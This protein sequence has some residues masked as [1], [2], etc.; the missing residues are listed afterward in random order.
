MEIGAI[1]VAMRDGTP[2]QRL[3]GVRKTETHETVAPLL[4]S[5]KNGGEV[6]RRAPVLSRPK[7]REASGLMSALCLQNSGIDLMCETDDD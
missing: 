7:S 6:T 1:V 5:R 2:T 4:R 3:V